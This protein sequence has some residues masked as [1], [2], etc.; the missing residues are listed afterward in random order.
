MLGPDSPPAAWQSMENK[1]EKQRQNTM[2]GPKW[3]NSR[4]SMAAE[5]QG[6]DP[7]SRI[8]RC[9]LV[10]LPSCFMTLLAVRRTQRGPYGTRAPA[11]PRFAG[12]SPS[13]SKRLHTAMGLDFRSVTVKDARPPPTRTNDPL[14][15]SSL[16]AAPVS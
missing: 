8:P 11:M 12:A 5:P 1:E 4:L 2:S 13:D 10:N 15:P 7:W 3:T 9:Q 16:R 6:L 14:T